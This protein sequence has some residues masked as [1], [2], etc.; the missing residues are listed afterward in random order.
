MATV[1]LTWMRRVI[2]LIVIIQP[3]EH[4]SSSR[5]EALHTGNDL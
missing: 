1:I 2:L 4:G 5:F 3:E